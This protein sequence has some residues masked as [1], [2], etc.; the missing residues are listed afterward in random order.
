MRRTRRS[1]WLVPLG[2]ACAIAL[3]TAVPCGAQA[4]AG[5]LARG[6]DREIST[7]YDASSDRTEVTLTLLLPGRGGT[8]PQTRL[9]FTAQFKGREAGAGP[10]TFS[11]R[12]HFTPRADPRRRDPRT[13]I[14]DRDLLFELDPHTSTGIRLYLYA[15]NYGYGGFVPPGDEVPVAFFTL[16]AAE[17]RALSVTSVITGRAVGHEFALEPAQLEALREFAHRAIR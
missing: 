3:L 9:T 7:A 13:L 6:Q 1:P 5:L 15:A 2:A 12:T 8:A 16:S 4:D 11:V 10:T 14:D 17:L